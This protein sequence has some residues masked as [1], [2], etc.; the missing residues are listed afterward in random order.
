MLQVLG[1]HCKE[2]G[3]MVAKRAIVGMLLYSHDLDGIVSQVSYP[4]QHLLPEAG[5]T[6]D[7][8]LC[9]AHSHVAL[10][11]PEGIRLAWPSVFEGVGGIG[12]GLGSWLSLLWWSVVDSV[13]LNL[14]P[15]LSGEQ[16]Q[17]QDQL[18]LRPRSITVK[19]CFLQLTLGKEYTTAYLGLGREAPLAFSR[20]FI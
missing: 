6:V 20:L 14:V 11:N 18:F 17:D 15:F 12:R 7:F 1:T 3:D 13:E 5:V 9:R 10:I 2:I 4:W 19:S 16:F 8:G